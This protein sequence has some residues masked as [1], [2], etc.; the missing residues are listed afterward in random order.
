MHIAAAPPTVCKMLFT[1]NVFC[2][3][4]RWSWI[5]FLQ[6]YL[7]SISNGLLY[8]TGSMIGESVTKPSIYYVCH[9]KPSSP[10]EAKKHQVNA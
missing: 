4:T 3:H 10:K 6:L 5:L 8:E 2:H 1:L 9:I 7:T